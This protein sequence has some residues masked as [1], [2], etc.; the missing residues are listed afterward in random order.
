M[1]AA[2][3]PEYGYLI[4]KAIADNRSASLSTPAL[5]MRIVEDLLVLF[6]VEILK[7]VRAASAPRRTRSFRSTC[8]AWS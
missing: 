8:K 4:E 5:V 7:I 6:G 1:K 3:M 2:T